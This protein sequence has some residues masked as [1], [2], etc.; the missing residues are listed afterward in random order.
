M[1]CLTCRSLF[2]VFWEFYLLPGSGDTH[3]FSPSTLEEEA[4]GCL[5]AWGQ[6]D[7][8]SKSQ[9]SYKEK[10]CIPAASLL[11]TATARGSV[12]PTNTCT[13]W[14][15]SANEQSCFWFQSCHRQGCP[16]DRQEVTLL[17]PVIALT[18]PSHVRSRNVPNTFYKITEQNQMDIRAS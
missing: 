3:A 15:I 11:F 13:C 7:L 17:F 14:A 4:G 10:P 12:C 2:F 6:S 8:Q 5:W 16:H 1:S 18:L 9:D